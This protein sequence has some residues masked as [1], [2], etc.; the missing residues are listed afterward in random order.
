MKIDHARLPITQS[1]WGNKMSITPEP[2]T[3]EK[4]F[5]ELALARADYMDNCGSDDADL[6][7]SDYFKAYN[8]YWKQ[9]DP[10][11]MKETWN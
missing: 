10:S 11:K 4:M 2:K 8:A 6:F 7:Y 5:S 9:V 1:L 3:V